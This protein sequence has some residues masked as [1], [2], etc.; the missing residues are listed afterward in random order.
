MSR[1]GLEFTQLL[2]EWLPVAL[3]KAMKRPGRDADKNNLI[4]SPDGKRTITAI[5]SPATYTALVLGT[6]VYHYYSDRVSESVL[7]LL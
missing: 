3:S 7:E 4:F 1:R 5:S 6:L 2:T